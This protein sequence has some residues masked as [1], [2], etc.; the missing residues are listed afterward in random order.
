MQFVVFTVLL[1][2]PKS[3]RHPDTAALLRLAGL[4]GKLS[5]KLAPRGDQ[6][7]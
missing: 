3:S 5:A 2:P 1:F 7:R 4:L 6:D